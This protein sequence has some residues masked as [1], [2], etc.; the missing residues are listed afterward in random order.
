MDGFIPVNENNENLFYA[1]WGFIR[2]FAVKIVT[3]GELYGEDSPWEGR[4]EG[5]EKVIS[6]ALYVGWNPPKI[7]VSPSG[8]LK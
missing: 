4:Y 5:V 3:C 6:S 2:E 8:G 7:R 1:I